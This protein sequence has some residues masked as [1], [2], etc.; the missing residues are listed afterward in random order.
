MN[1]PSL[2]AASPAASLP[3]DTEQI[4]AAILDGARLGAPFWAAQRDVV[5][6]ARALFDWIDRLLGEAESLW[7]DG[8]TEGAARAISAALRARISLQFASGLFA[9]EDLV[10]LLKEGDERLR[11]AEETVDILEDD[12]YL[13][14]LQG[15][16]ADESTWW[17]RRRAFIRALPMGVLDAALM[18]AS[19][20]VDPPAPPPPV[21]PLVPAQKA[22]APPWLTA[23]ARR[24]VEMLDRMAAASGRPASSA[25][26][27]RFEYYLAGR[28]PRGVEP[29]VEVHLGRVGARI[30][31][32]ARVP[33][34]LGDTLW[35]LTPI[36]SASART[37]KRI[38]SA[39]DFF[40][41]PVIR[42]VPDLASGSW[43]DAGVLEGALSDA[44]LLAM[45]ADSMVLRTMDVAVAD[46]E[47]ANAALVEAL[48]LAQDG[49]WLR[50]LAEMSKIDAPPSPDLCALAGVYLAFFLHVPGLA[51]RVCSLLTP[52]VRDR[53]HRLS[54]L[55]PELRAALSGA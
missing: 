15:C 42:V 22:G 26:P 12:E 41:I 46:D 1:K 28:S 50:A 52:D 38:G 7:A 37:L 23:R 4:R 8:D 32:H 54:W 18:N 34:S 21:V 43:F 5:G 3:T 17:G 40:G 14:L 36:G 6:A 51:K 2:S 29:G 48:D 45:G 13:D 19:H 16:V 49:G 9:R 39:D 24:S 11:A 55:A 10:A 20:E 44:F 53:L 25:V 35:T 30:G 33:Q 47:A 31:L 27:P